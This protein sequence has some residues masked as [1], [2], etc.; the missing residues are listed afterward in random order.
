VP[1]LDAGPALP[2]P[3]TERSL[4]NARLEAQALDDPHIGVEHL[5]LGLSAMNSGLV[6]PILSA[7]GPPAPVLRAAIL[8]RYRPTS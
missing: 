7:L 5:A 4:H 8:D 1:T 3:G 6:P 2:T